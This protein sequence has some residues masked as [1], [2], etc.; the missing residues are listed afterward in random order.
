MILDFGLKIKGRDRDRE[1]FDF[2][3][4]IIRERDFGF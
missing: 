2:G 1:I 4:G 3:L